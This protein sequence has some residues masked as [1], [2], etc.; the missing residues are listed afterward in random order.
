MQALFHAALTTVSEKTVSVIQIHSKS[1]AVYMTLK[2]AFQMLLS[3]QGR[4]SAPHESEKKLKTEILKK[5]TIC[6][7]DISVTIPKLS[8]ATKE[9]EH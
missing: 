9:A 1:C 7:A 3:I 8:A 2:S 6:S 5:Q 4:L